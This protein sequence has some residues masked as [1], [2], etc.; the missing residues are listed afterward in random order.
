MELMLDLAGWLLQRS[1]ERVIFLDG[2]PFSRRYQ[3]ENVLR[4]A[5]SLHQSWRILECVC[6]EATAKGRL[7]AA[8]DHPAG[9]RTA[10]LYDDVRARFEAILEPKTLVDTEMPLEECVRVG[11]AALK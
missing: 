6:S 2:R 3:I 11:L 10:A 8:S 9:N 1:P 4:R 5:A 7:A